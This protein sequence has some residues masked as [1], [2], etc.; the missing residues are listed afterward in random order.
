LDK[1]VAG[2]NSVYPVWPLWN[3]WLNPERD[4]LSRNGHCLKSICLDCY[5]I[6]I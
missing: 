2:A 4:G 3:L 6:L 5:V 1:H